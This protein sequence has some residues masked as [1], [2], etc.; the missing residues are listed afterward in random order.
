[1]AIQVFYQPV[2]VHDHQ[3]AGWEEYR[4]EEIELLFSG[5]TRISLPELLTYFGTAGTSVMTVGNIGERNFL[6]EDLCDHIDLRCIINDP[7]SVLDAIFRCEIIYSFSCHNRFHDR[8]DLIYIRIG[9]K[10]RFRMA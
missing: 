9:Q 10:Y 3:L 4:Q 5:M 7:E 1:M 6:T 8:G 2:I